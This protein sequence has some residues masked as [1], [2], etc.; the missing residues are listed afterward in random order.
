[1]ARVIELT[2]SLGGKVSAESQM[3]SIMCMDKVIQS[4]Y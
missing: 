4:C 3:Q 2:K 1:M